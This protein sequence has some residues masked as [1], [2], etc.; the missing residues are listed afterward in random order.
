MSSSVHIDSKRKGILIPSDG[1]TRR[2]D[3]TAFIAEKEF[4]KNF[5]ES[6]KTFCLS[7]FYILNSYLFVNATKICLFKAKDSEIKKHPLC[8][9]SISKGYFVDN[10]KKTGLNRYVY[11]FSFDYHVIDT[12]NII[13]VHKCLMKKHDI[14]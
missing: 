13:D 7:M 1:T 5:T 12:S 11:D 2:L 8:L 4:P 6:R 3:G 14:K 10:M 9:G